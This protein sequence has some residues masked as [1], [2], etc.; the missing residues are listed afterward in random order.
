[1]FTFAAEINRVGEI[2]GAWN[3]SL[4]MD[5]KPQQDLS[6]GVE[7]SRKGSLL[8]GVIRLRLRRPFQLKIPFISKKLREI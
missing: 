7:L 8:R 4:P 5:V 3:F 2:K 1:M 6:L